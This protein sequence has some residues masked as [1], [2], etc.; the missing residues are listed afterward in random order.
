MRRA[1][2]QTRSEAPCAGSPEGASPQA[3]RP[4]GEQPQQTS[5]QAIKVKIDP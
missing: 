4:E 3:Q 5:G 1:E 2:A